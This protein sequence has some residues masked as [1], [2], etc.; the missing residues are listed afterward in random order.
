M[1]SGCHI[2]YI[3]TLEEQTSVYLSVSLPNLSM[4]LVWNKLADPHLSAFSDFAR[5]SQTLTLKC[6]MITILKAMVS[7]GSAL[8]KTGTRSHHLLGYT[9]RRSNIISVSMPVY[10]DP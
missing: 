4:M 2:S 1:E 5:V 3:K 9:R 6:F 10:T 8:P 7:S